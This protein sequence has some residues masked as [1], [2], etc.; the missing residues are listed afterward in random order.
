MFNYLKK[1]NMNKDINSMEVY[2]GKKISNKEFKTNVK[3]NLNRTELTKFKSKY[4]IKK[5]NQKIYYY[6][7]MIHYIDIDNQYNALSK[8]FKTNN[9]DK[10]ITQ[11][12]NIDFITFLNEKK[13]INNADFTCSYNYAL[14]ELI[15]IEEIKISDT[16]KLIL[17][18]NTIK[19]EI[20]KDK[21]W[22]ETI[23]LLKNVMEN[24]LFIFIK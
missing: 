12:T 22:V 2:F 17:F 5:Y 14:T 10:N 6:K 18:N 7:N 4:P 13:S 15:E 21:H 9:I 3:D 16:I 24:I 19:L 1:D 11:N 20:I 8:T 23:S